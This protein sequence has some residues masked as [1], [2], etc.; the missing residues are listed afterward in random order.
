M[1]LS[2]IYFGLYLRKFVYN[3]IFY[4]HTHKKKYNMLSHSASN[5]T[6]FDLKCHVQNSIVFVMLR[7]VFIKL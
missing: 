5:F 1:C 7:L 3:L 4:S 6:E 2:P